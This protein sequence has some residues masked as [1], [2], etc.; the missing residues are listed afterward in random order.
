MV[1]RFSPR[2]RGSGIV[3]VACAALSCASYP[4]ATAP[5]GKSARTGR[6][7]PAPVRNA[8]AP[9]SEAALPAVPPP[10]DQMMHV[11]EVRA[12]MK[13]YGL[14]VWH[15]TR[16]ERF[17][18][19]VLGV[20]PKA[21]VGTPLI[22]VRL[23][24]GP[25]SQRGAYLVQG[26]SGSPVYI[27]GKLLGAFSQGEAWPKEPI[28][29]VT[30]IETMLE[31]L[32]PKLSSVP[33]GGEVAFDWNA[34]VA[35][36][37]SALTAP[38]SGVFQPPGQ[39][40]VRLAAQTF[41][42]LALPVMVS[43]MGQRG[44]DRVG[45][46]LAPFNL[47]VMQGPGPMG[48]PFKAELGPGAALGVSLVTGDVDITA[49]GTVTYRRGSE[50]LAFGHPWMQLGAAEWPITTAWIHDVFPGFQ[51]SHKYG[52]AGEIVGTMTQDR[53]YSIAGRLGRVPPMI[54]VHYTVTD[55]SSGRTKSFDCRVANHPLLVGQLLPVAVNSGLFEVRPVPGDTVAH[56]KLT[57]ETEGA[58]RITRENV[59][60]DPQM[61]DVTAVREL[62]ELLG[63]MATN[64]FR[65]V[66]VKSLDMEV[67]FE[68]KRSTASVERVFLSQDRFEPGEEVQVGVVVRPYRKEP[69]VLHT[70]VR[71]PE[72]A[73]NGRALLMV[74]G[75]A[76]RVNLA[77]LLSGG[78][79]G[80]L[81]LSPPPDASLRQVVRRFQERERNDQIV[82]RLIF[83]TSAVNVRGERLAQLPAALVDV[84]RSSKTTGFRIERDEAKA[85]QLTDYV[86]DGLQTLEI[87]IEKQDHLEKPPAR[88]GALSPSPGGPALTPPSLPGR[89]P[90]SLGD[91]AD[92]LNLIRFTVDG[93]PRTVRLTPEDEE[94]APVA[95]PR[96]PER[97]QP[98]RRGGRRGQQGAAAPAAKSAGPG[99]ASAS[100]AGETRAA[101]AAAPDDK[102]VG[103]A[104]TVWTQS[105]ATDFERGTLKGVAVNS[106]GDVRLSPALKL[107]HESSEQFVWSVLPVGDRLYAGTG[108][109]GLV[110]KLEGSDQASVVCRTGELQVHALA[111]DAAGNVYAGTSPN[112]K[113]FRIAP[114]GKSSEVWSMNGAQPS[115]EAGVKFILS[116]AVGADGALYAGTGPQGRIYR[117]GRGDSEPQL[118]CTLPTRSVMSLL[119]APDGS[120]YAGTA[121]DGAVYRIRIEGGTGFA[122]I[123]YDSD[124]T[125]ITG[126]A[127][128]AAGALFA[129][130]APAG[131]VF[132][133]E[134]DGTPRVHYE[135]GR[136]ALYGLLIDAGGNLYSGT[137]SSIVRIEGDGSATVLTDRRNGQFTC[138][139]WDESGRLVAGS[140][141]VGSVYRLN[142]TASGTFE[143]TVHDARLP[144]RW[145]RVR[146]TGTLPPGGAMDVHTRSGNTPEPDEAWSE[147]QPLMARDG[148]QFV[149]SP[150]A[151]F[152]QYRVELR[153]ERGSPSLKDMAIWYLPRNRAPRLTLTA[154]T[155]GEI[156]K[157]S[158]TLRWSGTDPDSDTLTYELS[159]SADGG[160]TWRLVGEAPA[161]P[162]AAAPASTAPSGRSRADEALAQ[163]RAQ[164]EKDT[165]M[166]PAQREE[167]FQKARELVQRYTRENGTGSEPPA[168]PAAPAPVAPAARTPGVTRLATFA[169]DTR[170]VPDGVYLLRLVATDRASNPANA[171][172]DTRTSEPFIIA[173]A[174][175]QLF[176]MEKGI[177]VDAARHATITG[178]AIGRVSLK[179]AQYRVA[180]GEWTAI[181]SDDGIWD[182]ALENFRCVTTLPGAGAQEV[183]VKVVD[184]AGNVQSARVRV[185][186]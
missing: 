136:G 177:V 25:I 3:L 33:A 18:V 122:T 182:S 87:Q 49:L 184:L 166:T 94:K 60:F 168:R 24:G 8:A 144:A 159:Y 79:P 74:Q 175:P 181:D 169:W 171:L 158:Q 124:Q 16:L 134:P 90:L 167:Q 15:G 133:I 13:G 58:G 53:P 115:A 110:L 86:V 72:N 112:G 23:S 148:S 80:S 83:P 179:G 161:A 1:A 32:D 65:R 61:I 176:L 98:E 129:A 62:Q 45:Q 135:R 50:L 52:S 67:V 11:S 137:G 26:M 100:P 113:L 51:V 97:Q 48:R 153:A 12:G 150:P 180:G 127:R 43:G 138:L 36:V 85:L 141:N 81:P 68:E 17:D 139:A 84:M 46:A 9:R 71:I 28:G 173:N 102:L 117:L 130:S 155:G 89:T 157:G 162:P 20:L 7:A 114:D 101:A 35:Q 172:E 42:P 104:T 39:Q 107:A 88:P 143:S 165:S 56:V 123:L 30:P 160:R 132:K 145:G 106:T 120:L 2:Y 75:G 77:P 44:L 34:P 178:F 69:V 54:P 147:W 64:S 103:R 108:S 95:G 21:N 29:M 78:A 105:T 119:A 140:A 37:A 82:A 118:L 4:A 27:N 174:A 31:A 152:L 38:E 55:R 47:A 92:E 128:D 22:L 73:T 76:T 185:G 183:E 19:E 66:P 163:Y 14:T 59:F 142:P 111:R 93:K 149:A 109:G 41:R 70:K 126:L 91:D 170:Q 99:T 186:G 40:S 151:R 131:Q 116:L 125:A 146:F 6:P 154:P 96:A 121:D 63:V 156:W 5:A 57:L 10:G 164:I